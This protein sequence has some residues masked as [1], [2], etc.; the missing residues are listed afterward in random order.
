MAST[1]R[2]TVLMVAAVVV[3]AAAMTEAQIQQLPSCAHKLIPC[4]QYL[5]NTADRPLCCE[6]LKYVMAHEVPCLCKFSR[7]NA[8]LSFSKVEADGSRSAANL[9]QECGVADTFPCNANGA[10]RM[11]ART[12]I[13]SLLI[14]GV[15]LMIL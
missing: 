1:T 2:V 14:L 8:M 12:A 5:N 15:L 9:A 3:L 10:G 13:S 11:I 6:R 7:D 4:V